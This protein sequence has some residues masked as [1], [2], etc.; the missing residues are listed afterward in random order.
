M[1]FEDHVILGAE[2]SIDRADIEHVMEVF[3][4]CGTVWAVD[5]SRV[6]GDRKGGGGGWRVAM[7]SESFF[8]WD[9]K[10]RDFAH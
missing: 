7:A 9:V 5:S 8:G 2:R 6:A 1:S 10:S 4:G 3:R